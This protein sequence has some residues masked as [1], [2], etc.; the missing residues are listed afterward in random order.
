MGFGFYYAG[1]IAKADAV[2][3]VDLLNKRGLSKSEIAN[4]IGITRGSIYQWIW[5]LVKDID[6][7]NKVRLLD[8]FYEID[9][10]E[11][12]N[13]IEE[14][15]RGHLKMLE[16]ERASMKIQASESVP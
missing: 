13:F 1:I 14:I 10:F 5:D 16:K 7:E 15:L 9:K 2:R 4:R 12:I 6:Y 8:L 3:I 11:A